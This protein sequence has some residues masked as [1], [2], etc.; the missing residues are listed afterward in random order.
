MALVLRQ[1]VANIQANVGISEFEYFKSNLSI[2]VRGN[3]KVNNLER[4][5]KASFVNCYQ[6]ATLL[7]LSVLYGGAEN[8]RLTDHDC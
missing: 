8:S 1:I 2:S 6:G 3:I 4:Y 7:E 5:L